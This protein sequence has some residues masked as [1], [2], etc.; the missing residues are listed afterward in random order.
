MMKK[1]MI[2]LVLTIVTHTVIGHY[3]NKTVSLS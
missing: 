3:A 1:L 2:L